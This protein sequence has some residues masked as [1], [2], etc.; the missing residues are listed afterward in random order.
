MTNDDSILE[1][2]L[3]AVKEWIN[4]ANEG[5]NRVRNYY[6]KTINELTSAMQLI[7]DIYEPDGRCSKEQIVQVK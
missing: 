6:P 5:K 1:D 3:V 4:Q 7:Y 2:P